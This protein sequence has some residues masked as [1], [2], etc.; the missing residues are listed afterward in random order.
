MNVDHILLV[1]GYSETSLGAYSDLP[2]ILTESDYTVSQIV[3]SAFNSLDDTVTIDDLALALEEH[4]QD[5]EAIGWALSK[6]A[7]ICH[8]TGAL[9]VRRWMLNRRQLSPTSSVPSHLITMAGAN[10]GSTLAQVGKS[11]L[12]YVQKLL[13]DHVLSVGASVL[14]DL[15]YGSNFLLRLNREWLEASNDRLLDDVFAFSMGGDSLGNDKAVEFL[16][17]SSEPGCDNTV[18][19]SGANLNYRFLIADPDAGT[20]N[21]LQPARRV[22][23]LIVPGKSHFGPVTGILASIHD[24][25]DPAFVAIKRALDV[26]TAADYAG[27][28]SD[29]DGRVA[30]WTNQTAADGTLANAHATNATLVFS[31]TDRA[32]HPVEDCFIGFLDKATAASDVLK[33]LTTS[34]A[35]IL[36]HSP[37]QN[38]VQRGSYSFYLNWPKY[39]MVEH[40]LHIEAHAGSPYITYKAVDYQP[41]SG[42]EK[43]IQPNEFTYVSIKIDRDAYQTYALYQL[44]EPLDLSPWMP[45]PTRGLISRKP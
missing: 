14:T 3:L 31:V 9:V 33:A 30:A 41:G 4:V 5:L 25:S 18:R 10:H 7:V 29:W 15:D 22:P 43:M 44:G 35:A 17:Q 27:V 16:W 1:H 45:F 40:L 12:G 20:L 6:T 28:Q 8:S 32:N 24:A 13:Q 37:I 26:E 23:H 36:P 2:R 11:V 19:I 34:S 21:F 38:D 42:V 39:K